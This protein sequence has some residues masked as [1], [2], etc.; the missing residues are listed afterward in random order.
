MVSDS[1]AIV[2]INK[3]DRDRPETGAHTTP[4]LSTRQP[5]ETQIRRW[6]ELD[7]LLVARPP[8]P[9]KH[10]SNIAC[11]S[12][13]VMPS[14]L[15][16]SMYANKIYFIV[17]LLLVGATGVFLAREEGAMRQRECRERSVLAFGD[18]NTILRFFRHDALVYNSAKLVVLPLASG[19]A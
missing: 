6:P 18:E 10:S 13:S 1:D 7:R 3:Q 9:S 15:P 11:C 5:P 17:L 4:S 12:P 14:R 2:S 16:F 8:P 19:V